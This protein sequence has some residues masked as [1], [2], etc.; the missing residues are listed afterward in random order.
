VKAYP[1]CSHVVETDDAVVCANCG[2]DWNSGEFAGLVHSRALP[3]G[4]L[5]VVAVVVF[6]FW[7]IYLLI[8][9]QKVSH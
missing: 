1:Y 8:G 3:S 5:T 6:L 4:C 7:L 9:S 2:R